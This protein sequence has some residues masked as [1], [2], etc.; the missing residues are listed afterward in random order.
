LL[1]EIGCLQAAG[2]QVAFRVGAR[3]AKPEIYEVLEERGADYV[4]RTAAN[5]SLELDIEDVLF[6]PPAGRA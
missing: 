4:V 3:F 2:K 5:T 1:P 6:H